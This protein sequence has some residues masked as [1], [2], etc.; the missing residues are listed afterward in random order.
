MTLG[1]AVSIPEVHHHPDGWIY[2]RTQHGTYVDTPLN[3]SHDWKGEAFPH[4]PQRATERLYRQ[5]VFH[6]VKDAENVIEGGPMPWPLGDK[7]IAAFDQ[8]V[9]NQK[10]RTDAE[11][12]ANAKSPEQMAKEMGLPWPPRDLLKEFDALV[13]RV[14]ALEKKKK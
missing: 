8:L 2:V 14:E 5:G 3:F 7:I 11:A 1:P 10:V 9:S 13:A 6:C 12:K 4:L